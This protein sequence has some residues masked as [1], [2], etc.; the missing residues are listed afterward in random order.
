[1]IVTLHFIAA[2]LRPSEHI[3]IAYEDEGHSST[4]QHITTYR[5]ESSDLFPRE[6]YHV[7]HT[8]NLVLPLHL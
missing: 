4:Q 7:A 3:A 8:C 1:M 6:K 5:L 2:E